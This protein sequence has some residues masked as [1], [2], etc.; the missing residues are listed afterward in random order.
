VLLPNNFVAFELQI[1]APLCSAENVFIYAY[2][3]RPK[4]P[5]PVYSFSH[6]C[7]QRQPGF[8]PGFFHLVVIHSGALWHPCT[9]K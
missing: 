5:T 4:T 7:S 2:A 8:F 3:C 6:H 1:T 9:R